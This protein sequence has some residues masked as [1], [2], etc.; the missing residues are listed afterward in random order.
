MASPPSSS[1]PEALA[2]ELLEPCLHFLASRGALQVPRTRE[3][4]HLVHAPFALLPRR[5]PAAALRAARALARPF[6][7]LVDR[8][9]R[10][11]AW[12]LEELREAGE[13]DADFTGQL[14]DLL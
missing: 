13:A 2:A 9:A 7:S 14:L 6:S 5:L 12:L 11:T 3:G 10:D 4:G 8:V 1:S